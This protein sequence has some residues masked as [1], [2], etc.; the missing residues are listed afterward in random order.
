MLRL[1]VDP[2]PYNLELHENAKNGVDV[3]ARL[4]LEA[5]LLGVLPSEMPA[6]WPLESLKAQ[7]VAARS[8]VLRKAYER[9]NQAYD[10]DST[11][12]DQVYKFLHEAENHPEWSLKV[13]RAVR[14]TRGEVL[15]DH[16]RRILKAF[17][18]ADCGCTTEDPK[19]VWGK[20]TPPLNPSRIRRVRCGRRRTGK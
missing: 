4:D 11:I 19:F 13:Q 3:I 7:A 6:A 10:V 5:Y 17:Y 2:V 8:F 12:I 14:E 18:S 20:R 16:R 15:V 9:R 1:G